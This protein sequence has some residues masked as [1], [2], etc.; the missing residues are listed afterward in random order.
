[1]CQ[2]DWDGVFFNHK[3]IFGRT[4]IP[5]CFSLAETGFPL[6]SSNTNVCDLGGKTDRSL[7]SF[8]SQKQFHTT[9]KK[10]PR[11]EKAMAIFNPKRQ[12]IYS[13][14]NIPI[15]IHYQEETSSSSEER[16]RRPQHDAQSNNDRGDDI[17][18]RP[19]K[20]M[21]RNSSSVQ[22]KANVDIKAIPPKETY[23]KNACW[24]PEGSKSQLEKTKKPMNETI[25]RLLDAV[26][27]EQ[28]EQWAAG[29][30]NPERL[31][32]ASKQISSPFQAKAL[33]DGILDRVAAL[34]SE[35]K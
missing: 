19:T 20:R 32:N 9:S 1:M 31:A 18:P 15:P 14:M 11:Q 24:Y 6:C 28:I 17:S 12:S 33:K 30:N 25:Q 26:L 21:R 7:T 13:I 10:I 3:D 5:I 34:S 27:D 16:I 29:V 8:V 4:K 23:D 35:S 22:F 2:Y